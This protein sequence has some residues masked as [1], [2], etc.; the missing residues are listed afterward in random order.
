MCIVQCTIL[1]AWG[2]YTGMTQRDGMGREEGEGFRMGNTCIPVA[3]S[4]WYMA[5]PIQYCKVK[6]L[7]KEKKVFFTLGAIKKKNVY[8]AF[9]CERQKSQSH[10]DVWRHTIKPSQHL[11]SYVHTRYFRA[12]T[13]LWIS[14]VSLQ[15]LNTS[16]RQGMLQH[17]FGFL[18]SLHLGNGNPLRCSCLE[19]PQEGGAWWTA[20]YGVAQS[21]TRL[22]WLSNSSS[23]VS[24]LQH[25][26]ERKLFFMK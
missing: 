26:S 9:I 25:N 2:W 13:V 8:C 20:V 4:F 21:R 23:R 10:T 17:Q 1:D 24:F 6:K 12:D 16:Y 19:N 5:K 3:D 14:A 7:K 15:D 11:Q 18:Q 22:K